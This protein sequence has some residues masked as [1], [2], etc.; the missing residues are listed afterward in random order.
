MSSRRILCLAGC[1]VAAFASQAPAAEAI[2]WA[3]NLSAAINMASRQN[4]LV[5]LHFWAPGCRP[6]LALEQNVFTRNDVADAIARDFVPVKINAEAMPDTARK[7][8][9]DRWPMDV[10]ITPAGY[11][12]HASVSPGDPR[13]YMQMLYRVAAQRRPGNLLSA[14]TQDGPGAN[15]PPPGGQGWA[16]ME[17]NMHAPLDNGAGGAGGATGGSRFTQFGGSGQAPLDSPGVGPENHFGDPHAAPFG[18]SYAN[19]FNQPPLNQSPRSQPPRNPP[20][21]DPRAPA[22]TR[23]EEPQPR[24]TVN[25][26]IQNDPRAQ[27]DMRPQPPAQPRS[28]PPQAGGRPPLGLDGFC[29]VTLIEVGKW[30]KGDERFGI[31]HRGR[32]Y[33]FANEAE[34]QRFWQDPDRYAP[35]LSGNDPVEFAEGGHVVPGNRK[36]GVFFRN[37]IYLFTT[38]ES[39]ERFW[40][41]PQRYADV[42][43]QAMRRAQE[44]QRR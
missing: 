13:G 44:R 29:P 20:Q 26:Y 41:S 9:V 2:Q 5:L 18:P 15:A 10:I 34:K 38:E 11:P 22:D 6:C 24:E 12:V 32:L 1:L 7:Y 31:I 21:Q 16:A 27:H 17:G 37:Q 30:T 3:P 35:I 36:H 8:K 42:A 39:L 23:G 33:L 43:Q 40:N 14:N 19:Q 4:R 25:P 28:Q